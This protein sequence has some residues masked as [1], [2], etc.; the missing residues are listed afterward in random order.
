MVIGRLNPALA[1]GILTTA[2]LVKASPKSVA[3]KAKGKSKY[4]AKRDEGK[5]TFPQF[6]TWFFIFCTQPLFAHYLSTVGRAQP[7]LLN[8]IRHGRR[9]VLSRR[10][11]IGGRGKPRRRA[12]AMACK[13]SRSRART[14]TG[15]ATDR[16]S[17]IQRVMVQK[18]T[19]SLSQRCKEGSQ[20]VHVQGG[21]GAERFRRKHHK[22]C[23]LPIK[24]NTE[25]SDRTESEM[26]WYVKYQI[27]ILSRP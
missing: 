13:M 23:Q 5:K 21:E 15:T 25:C 4:R 27:S 19:Q 14:S 24:R 3:S 9:W 7:P 16:N 12:A 2:L 18:L 20:A 11:R 17:N 6:K 10:N 22:S 8:S 1:C 26:V